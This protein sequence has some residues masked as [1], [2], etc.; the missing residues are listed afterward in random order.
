MMR[1]EPESDDVGCEIWVMVIWQGAMARGSRVSRSEYA[2]IPL[3]TM[4]FWAIDVYAFEPSSTG[5]CSPPWL[6]R[7]E[8]PD[9]KGLLRSAF[10]QHSGNY[11]VMTVFTCSPASGRPA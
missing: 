3:N 10:D 5:R 2:V 9:A 8:R 4:P 7:D 1:R 11:D 6:L